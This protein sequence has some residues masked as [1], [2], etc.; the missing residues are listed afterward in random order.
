MIY[1]GRVDNQ[2]KIQGY[3][4]ELGEIEAV[5]REESGAEVAVA[6][7]WPRLDSGVEGIVGFVGA[8][9]ADATAILERARARLP[10]YMRPS[11]I[12]LVSTFPLNANGKVDRK[13]LLA[14]LEREEAA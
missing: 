6:I 1:L 4:V 5:L 8:P 10:S 2:I 7:G 3:R 13:A 14:E 11:A 12:R 9:D